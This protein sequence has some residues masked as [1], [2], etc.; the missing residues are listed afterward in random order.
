MAVKTTGAEF[1]RFYDDPAVWGSGDDAGYLE[2]EVVEV[3][4][5]EQDDAAD[6]SAVADGAVI[7]IIDGYICSSDGKAVSFEQA[8]KKWRKS[9]SVVS[10]VVE[11][12][13]VNLENVLAAI[14]KAGGKVLK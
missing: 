9:Q 12:D 13:K 6:L 3:D 7:K 2:D 14:K 11:C 4:G 10:L 8:F 5:V 1:K